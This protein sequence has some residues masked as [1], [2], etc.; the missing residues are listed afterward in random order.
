MLNHIV[1]QKFECVIPNPTLI[2]YYDITLIGSLCLYLG[3][4]MFLEYHYKV[5]LNEILGPENIIITKNNT[6]F[7]S[8]KKPI[9]KKEIKKF[10]L[11]K[12]K[13]PKKFKVVVK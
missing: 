8:K 1:V 5:S 3:A 7:H 2:L 10:K 13:A 11:K 4:I 12:D 6:Y 9:G